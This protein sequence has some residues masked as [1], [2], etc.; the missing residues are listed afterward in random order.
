VSKKL[1]ETWDRS[2]IEPCADE[3]QST[4]EI[5]ANSKAIRFSPCGVVSHHPDDVRGT[6]C[7]YCHRF[8]MTRK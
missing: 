8:I 2:M 7:A 1:I 4:Y 3:T 6:Y 5:I